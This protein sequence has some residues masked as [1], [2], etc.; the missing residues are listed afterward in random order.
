[1]NEII[2]SGEK[3]NSKDKIA[4]AIKDFWENIGGI[5]TEMK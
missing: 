2:V 3:V 5:K 1:M 4:M